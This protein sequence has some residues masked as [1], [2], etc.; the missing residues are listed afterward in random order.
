MLIKAFPLIHCSISG[1]SQ[2]MIPHCLK[3][4][5]RLGSS[6]TDMLWER[7]NCSSRL[8]EVNIWLCCY[9]RACPRMEFITKTE[10]IRNWP[11]VS[12]ASISKFSNVIVF[13]SFQSFF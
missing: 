1:N 8:Y 3:D 10:R 7:G 12:A 4:N 13:H 5:F 6:S 11:S 2:P 9:G